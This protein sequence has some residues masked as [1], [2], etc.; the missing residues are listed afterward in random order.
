METK[1]ETKPRKKPGRVATEGRGRYNVMLDDDL[2][3]WAKHQP[4]G[5]SETLRRLLVDAK[6]KAERGK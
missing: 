6:A 2:A 1:Q 4:G 3:E 5:M